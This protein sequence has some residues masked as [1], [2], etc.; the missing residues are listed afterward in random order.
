MISANARIAATVLVLSAPLMTSN[1]KATAIL[2][3]FRWFLRRRNEL[4]L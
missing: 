3:G 2:T 1:P 4:L